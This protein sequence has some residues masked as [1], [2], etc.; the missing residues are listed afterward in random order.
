MVLNLIEISQHFL[1][2]VHFSQLDP[3]MKHLELPSFSGKF[4]FG[5]SLDK[6]ALDKAKVQVQNYLEVN[7]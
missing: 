5:K 2:C 6:H 4:I 7:N 3:N 1:N